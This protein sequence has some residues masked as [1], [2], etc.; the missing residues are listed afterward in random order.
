MSE[1]PNESM[2][3]KLYIIVTMLDLELNITSVNSH[4]A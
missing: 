3:S 2:S 1:N 4:L